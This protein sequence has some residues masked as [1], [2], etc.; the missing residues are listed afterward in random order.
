[1]D[2]QKRSAAPWLFGLAAL[3]ALLS[4][5]IFL[6]VWVAAGDLEGIGVALLAGVAD[7]V[8]AAIAAITA[9]VLAVR[10]GVTRVRTV[11]H[12]HPQGRVGR[13]AEHD[14]ARW[15]LA[16]RRFGELQAEYAAFEASRAAVAARPALADVTVPA[17]ARFVQA[18]GD[19]EFLATETEPAAA[20]SRRVHRR[21]RPRLR[22]VGGRPARRGG[23]RRGPAGRVPRRRGAGRPVRPSGPPARPAPSTR[24]PRGS[25]LPVRVH[26][27]RRRRAPRRRPRGPRPARP[28][29]RLTSRSDG[30][31][32][33]GA[34]HRTGGS[35]QRSPESAARVLPRRQR[36]WHS[37]EI[38]RRGPA[39]PRRSERAV[40]CFSAREL[41]VD[42]PTARTACANAAGLS[43]ST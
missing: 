5:V 36:W 6:A 15:H 37:G 23:S 32:A 7:L 30:L 14:A 41:P 28:P 17:T 35:P 26:P 27:G 29:A 21:R 43:T 25:P 3:L 22:G 19:A 24:R 10:R 13:M 11:V 12:G 39:R 2:R 31:L 42:Q 9:T 4:P 40:R 18:L 34:E 38:I 8:L 1:M 20:P 16:R 33:A